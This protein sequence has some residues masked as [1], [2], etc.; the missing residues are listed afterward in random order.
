MTATRTINNNLIRLN[1]KLDHMNNQLNLLLNMQME[2]NSVSRFS[3]PQR[4]NS[5]RTM[6][7]NPYATGVSFMAGQPPN[8]ENMINTLINE[9][10]FT[11]P[12]PP[13]NTSITHNTIL[14][15]TTI[16][17]TENENEQCSICHDNYQTNNIVRKINNC[18]HYFH[19]RCLD[20]WLIDNSTCPDRKSVV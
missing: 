4:A 16:D 20:T 17:I 1:L 8:L 11:P 6:P 18:G 5:N 13:A 7:N 2:D 15:N 10:P 12:A 3:Y 19:H 14:I 9:M